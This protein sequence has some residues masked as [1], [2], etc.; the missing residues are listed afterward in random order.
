VKVVLDTNTRL[1][2]DRGRLN[3]TRSKEFSTIESALSYLDA[4]MRKYA[5]NVR[6]AEFMAKVEDRMNDTDKHGFVGFSWD[7]RTPS[8][9]LARINVYVNA[10]ST[11]KG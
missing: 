10:L 1:L 8:N 2:N 7:F 6:S 4:W 5:P 11:P 3:P 9:H